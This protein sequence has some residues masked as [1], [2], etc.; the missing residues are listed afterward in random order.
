ML[1]A[2]NSFGAVFSIGIDSLGMSWD[3]KTFMGLCFGLL[4]CVVCDVSIRVP[5]LFICFQSRFVIV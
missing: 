1:F 3:R 5:F 4:A 2:V